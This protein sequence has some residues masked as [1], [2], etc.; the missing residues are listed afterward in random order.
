MSLYHDTVSRAVAVLAS[1]S[2]APE[3]FNPLIPTWLVFTISITGAVMVLIGSFTLSDGISKKQRTRDA[4]GG[5]HDD[6]AQKLS[7]L[8]DAS[9]KHTLYFVIGGLLVAFLPQ[10]V[11]LGVTR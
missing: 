7:T 5:G 11:Y 1:E 6:Q 10:V 3:I 2:T 9:F 4:L 8:A